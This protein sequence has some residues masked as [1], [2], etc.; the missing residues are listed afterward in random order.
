MKRYKHVLLIDDNQIDNLINRKMMEVSNFSEK[1]TV[2]PSVNVALKWLYTLEDNQA[3]VPELIFLDI[4]MPEMNGFDFLEEFE[5]LPES[6]KSKIKIYMLSSS[7]NPTD[8]NK[9]SS[10]Q[11]VAKFLGK[12]LTQE[13]LENI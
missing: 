6:V 5:K 7:L 10:N 12:P 4:R 8:L 9:I 1:I 11:Y 2:Q 13:Q 3:E